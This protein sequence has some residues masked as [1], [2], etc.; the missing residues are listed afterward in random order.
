MAVRNAMSMK[1]GNAGPAFLAFQSM[2]KRQTGQKG[3][4]SRVSRVGST[5]TRS[6]SGQAG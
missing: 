5:A 1:P 2:D 4:T 6:G 3:N